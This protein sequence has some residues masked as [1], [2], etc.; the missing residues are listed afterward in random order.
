MSDSTFKDIASELP[1]KDAYQDLVH[2][3]AVAFGKTVSL[4][5][6]AVN[7]LLT[8]IAKWILQGEA[9]LEAVSQL[10]AK[11]V[12]NVP[13]EKLVPPE[14]YVAV[15]AFQAISYSLDSD[16]LRDMYAK[17][18]AAAINTET[19]SK[20]HPAYVEMIKQLSPLDCRVLRDISMTMDAGT[21]VCSIRF[22]EVSN[23][24]CPELPSFRNATS[25]INL[26]CDLSAL[27][28]DGTKIGDISVSIGNL[29]RLG[30]L[31]NSGLGY[32]SL[33]IYKVFETHA[34]IIGMKERLA[35]KFEEED[36]E[37]ALIKDSV[38]ITPLGI[39]FSEVCIG[40]FPDNS[41]YHLIEH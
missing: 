22:Q 25:G 7:V 27:H 2:P 13:E 3:S 4:P 10:V 9:K 15:P 23:M 37:L 35:S 26:A 29:K 1:L 40:A 38:C 30:F 24:P 17:L 39:S 33:D 21:P 5:F 36:W 28:I 18:L 41:L 34:E 11:E 6:R 12:E 31:D 8:P 14:P 16:E 19:K 32:Q 20:A